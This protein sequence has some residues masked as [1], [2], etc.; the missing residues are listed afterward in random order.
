MHGDVLCTKS[1]REVPYMPWTLR[2]N[3]DLFVIYMLRDPRNVIVSKH[4]QAPDKYYTSLAVWQEFESYRRRL[5]EHPRFL[6]VKYE[7]LVTE[8]D[9]VQ[10]KIRT[11]M[12]F[13]EGRCLFSEFHHYARPSE[14]T[15]RAL[16]GLRPVSADRLLEWKKHLP[17]VK[18]QLERFGEI[19]AELVELGYEP[20]AKWRD[21]LRDV[22]P[23]SFDSV[24]D[25]SWRSASTV[26]M[27]YRIF[28]KIVFYAVERLLHR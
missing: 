12:P 28:R 4:R 27:K 17:R 23:Q 21:Q 24:L 25:D 7:E 20:D 15:S 18:A 19:S 16:N 26:K 5:E 6:V 8:P 2:L 11:L 3:P 1:P 9:T 10:E 14:R 13:L 22:E